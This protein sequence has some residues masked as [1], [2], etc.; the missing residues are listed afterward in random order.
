VAGHSKWANIK[1]RKD[2]QDQKRGKLWSKCARAIIAA[3]KSGGPDPAMNLTLRYAIDEARYANM[4]KDNIERAIKKG[5][6]E[7]GGEDYAAV[8]Y[9]GYGPGGVAILVDTLT[10]NRTR[11]VNELR[12]AFSKGGGNLGNSGCV[13]YLFDTRGQIMVSAEGID[14]EKI[15]EAAIEAGATDVQSPEPD[16]DDD[17]GYW[18]LT[19]EPTEFQAVKDALED[20]G[21]K[22][23]EAWIAMV[24]QNLVSLRG[25]DARKLMNLIDVL[26]DHDDAQK[27]YTNAD[28]PDEELAA[29]NN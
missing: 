11:T 19:T 17:A 18:T 5:A 10:D 9:E 6:G 12:T 25:D 26:E 13:A 21:F 15:M 22:I 29:L 27:V 2:R 4:P 7:G 16:D 3:A 28:I 8:R 24:P 1:H 23:S 14:E 20:A